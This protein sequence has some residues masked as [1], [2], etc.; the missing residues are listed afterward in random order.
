MDQFVQV[1][2]LILEDQEVNLGRLRI[3]YAVH[4]TDEFWR[5]LCLFKPLQ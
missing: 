1:Q 3:V 2:L 5:I 4:K